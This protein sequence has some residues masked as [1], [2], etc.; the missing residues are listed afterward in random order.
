MKEEHNKD[1]TNR[2]W[3][4]RMNKLIITTKLVFEH[5]PPIPISRITSHLDLLSIALENVMPQY[6]VVLFYMPNNIRSSGFM[7]SL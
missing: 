2:R 6:K 1:I 5:F 7:K 4:P 3:N